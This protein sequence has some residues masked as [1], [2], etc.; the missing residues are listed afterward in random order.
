MNPLI[1]DRIRLSELC[2]DDVDVVVPWFHDY[3]FLRLLDDDP[4]RP[5]SRESHER[6]YEEAAKAKDAYH[7]SIRT[8]DGDTLIGTCSLYDQDRRSHSA[9][10]GI[11]VGDK[12]YWGRGYGTEATRL[13]LR[14]AFYELNYHRVELEVFAYNARAIR[15]YEKAGFVQEATL[16][17]AVYREG[18]YHDVLVMGVLKDEWVAAFDL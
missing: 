10:F 2:R 7:F 11:G 8:L 6:W 18:A 5:L 13:T 17:E 9:T 12:A 4:V 1:G 16:R 15:A 14:A 3:E